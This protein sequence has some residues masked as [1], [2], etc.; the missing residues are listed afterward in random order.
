MIH[1]PRAP[2]PRSSQNHDAQRPVGHSDPASVSALIHDLL[3]VRVRPCLRLG[4]STEMC[5]LPNGNRA[6]GD[7]C[8]HRPPRPESPQGSRVPSRSSGFRIG[9]PR[10]AEPRRPRSARVTTSPTSCQRPSSRVVLRE[11]VPPANSPAIESPSRAS[12]ACHVHTRYKSSGWNHRIRNSDTEV[13]PESD[14]Q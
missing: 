12:V 14:E 8:P 6:G 1:E 9:D 4:Q 13:L 2:V 11:I 5:A 3:L 7:Q 10:R